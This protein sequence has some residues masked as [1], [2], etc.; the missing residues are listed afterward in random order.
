MQDIELIRKKTLSH[1][2]LILLLVSAFPL[3]VHIGSS[4]VLAAPDTH[5]WDGGGADAFA[6]THAN[7]VSN[8]APEAG[9]SVVF[10]AGAL[11]CTWNLSIAL[12]AFSI[13]VGYSGVVTQ[14]ASF[15]VTSYSQTAGTFTGAADFVMSIS[16]TFAKTG[17]TW[18]ANEGRIT[19][20]T[21]D[22]TASGDDISLYDLVVDGSTT[23]TSKFTVAHNLVVANGK[24]LTL[25]GVQLGWK[26]YNGGTYS[27]MGTI[28]GSAT[29]QLAVWNYGVAPAVSISFGVVN[30]GV[31]VTEWSP[32]GSVIVTATSSITL[33]EGLNV[34]SNGDGANTI[35]LGLSTNN[36]ALSA[37]TIIIGTGGILNGSASA[38]ASSGNVDFSAGQFNANKSLLLMNGAG[39]TIKT[40]NTNGAPYDLQIS[41]TITTL[42]SLNV[43]NNLTIDAGKSLTMGSGTNLIIGNMT[44]AGSLSLSS[45]T[46]TLNPVINS[47]SIVQNGKTL[48]ISGS[49]S[50]PLTGYGTFDGDLYLNG[51]TASNYEIQTGLPMG[52]LYTDRDTKISLDSTRY[53][54]VVPASTE[55]VSISISSIGTEQGYAARWTGTSTGPVTYTVPANANE[56]YDIWVDHTTRI[57]VVQTSDDGIVQF[58]YNGPFSTHEF[59][60]SKSSGPPTSLSASFSYS[61]S[62]NQVSF[63]D[64]SYGGVST[65]LWD[66]GDGTGST[67]QSPTHKYSKS[68]EY[69]VSLTVYDSSGHSSTAKTTIT[70]KLGPQ[71][72]VEPTPKGWNVW[73][74]DK[75]TVSVSALA[76]LIFGTWFLLAGYFPPLLPLMT[77]KTKKILGLIIIAIGLY[78]FVFV[79]N[80]HS[81]LGW[82]SG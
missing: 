3:I 11:P 56:L 1:A 59:T 28:S 74:S 76:L 33:G 25:T 38:I 34:D 47:G 82:G 44:S 71:F 78:W 9:D 32:L 77:P 65:Y 52:N 10:D 45:N 75:L 39:K 72:P 23:F 54:Q 18:S 63:T 5:T 14:G 55:F 43:T 12:N 16:S 41:G 8:I 37:D 40:A 42:S 29:G 68:G 51:S 26:S 2:I 19:F 69:V 35:T 30:V 67:S 27:N 61:I 58:T 15:E 46:Y 53:L 50:T 81:W 36:Y 62:G 64:K 13:N 73:V 6:G 7:W 80:S 79:D 21:D 31:W 49:S 60:V 4:N 24:V 22:A 57:G 48:N 20:T 70:L 66:F 17:G